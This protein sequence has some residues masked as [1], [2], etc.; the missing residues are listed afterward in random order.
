TRHAALITLLALLLAF[1]LSAWFFVPALAEQDLAQL[2]PVTEGYFHYSNHF[3]GRDLVQGGL[4][5]DYNPDGGVAF[6]LGLVQA[7]LG[8]AGAVALVV[9]WRLA[10]RRPSFSALRRSR[11][12]FI[13]LGTAV[14]VFMVTPLSR[15]LWDHLP[16][17]SFT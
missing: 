1:A 2:G 10:A 14:A 13:L 15:P 9:I 6:R 8:L 5:F 11:I 16:L 7:V 12:A 17:L 3:R 4:L